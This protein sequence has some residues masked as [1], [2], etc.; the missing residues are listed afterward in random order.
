[1]VKN[2]IAPMPKRILF[3]CPS[4][5]RGGA[6]RVTRDVADGLNVLGNT[7][8]I[9]TNTTTAITYKPTTDIKIY[10]H[11]TNRLLIKKLRR[12]SVIRARKVIKD[13]KPDVIVG[14]MWGDAL[15]AYIATRLIRKDI[16][17]VFSDHDS[18]DR[19]SF[20]KESL[21]KK[22]SKHILSKLCDW[23]TVLTEPDLILAKED[24]V[25]NVSVQINPLSLSPLPTLPE[26]KN[27]I[28][29][30]GR[31]DAWYYKGFD[32]LIKAW[33]RIA[34]NHPSFVLQF[35]GTGSEKSVKFLKKHIEDNGIEKQV[36]F[37]GF[38]DDMESIY[39]E[40]S[41]FVLSSRYEGFGLV[42]IEAMSQG[43]ACIACDFGG[44]QGDII[45]HG[46]NGLLCPIDNVDSLADSIEKLI[47]DKQLRLKVQNN[48]ISSLSKYS[49]KSVS[50]S[51]NNLINNICENEL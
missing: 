44:R 11:T 5:T 22:F 39:K 9:L 23:Y 12:F 28:L 42:L 46:Y 43:C 8:A 45:Q 15:V 16:P 17:V 1:M 37:L 31:L 19:P 47:S 41:I 49:K 18:F 3:M 26:K 48:A 13:F 25:K 20:V 29:A 38:R 6:E 30:V 27:T 32:L 14:V 7:V 33:G 51:W 10:S 35:A 21:I 36:E 4:L 34:K 50:L 24:G 2:S 40:S